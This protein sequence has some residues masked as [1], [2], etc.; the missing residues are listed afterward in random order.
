MPV[1]PINR[2]Q[3]PVVIEPHVQL[4]RSV[5]NP[6][7]SPKVLNVLS[8]SRIDAEVLLEFAHTDFI[9]LTAAVSGNPK[10]QPVAT[11]HVTGRYHCSAQTLLVVL[12]EM[13]AAARACVTGGALTQ[14]ALDQALS[15]NEGHGAH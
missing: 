4:K 7:E 10:Q 5:S 12:K 15:S 2:P 8:W 3:K 1:T 6:H 14:E 9:E 11:A 13:H